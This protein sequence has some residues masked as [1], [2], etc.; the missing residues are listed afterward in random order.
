[1]MIG[2]GLLGYAMR[3]LKYDSAPLV[4]AL[5]LGP[6]M[7]RSFREAMMISKG[8]LAVFV[9]R[10]ISATLLLVGLLVMV[11]PP[12]LSAIRKKG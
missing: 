4:L 2:F 11:V 5:V 10:P 6:M 7:E 3:R 9:T 1:L 12:I 8:D